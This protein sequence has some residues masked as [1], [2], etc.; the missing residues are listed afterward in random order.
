VRPNRILVGALLLT[1]A[2]L[3][4][5]FLLEPGPASWPME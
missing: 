1:A 2:L 3:I 4:G 5:L